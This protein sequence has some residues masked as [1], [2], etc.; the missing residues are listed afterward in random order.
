L[1]NSE[2]I[3]NKIF[4]A[5]EVMNSHFK[6]YDYDE[7]YEI[8]FENLKKCLSKENELFKRKNIQII[9]KQINPNVNFEYWKFYRILR[10]LYEDN[11]DYLQLMKD[12]K[13]YK[14]LINI[15]EK[16]DI[17]KKGKLHYKKM[18][19]ALLIEEKLRLNK[20]QVNVFYIDINHA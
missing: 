15:F 2:Y 13:I 9:L 20:I 4:H 12:D 10:I 14:Y 16:Q 5:V 6:E 19:Y 18:K 11:F 3:K 17:E 1:E 7:N 8:S